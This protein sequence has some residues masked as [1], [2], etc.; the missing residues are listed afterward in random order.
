MR[1]CR[2]NAPRASP[3]ARM[4]R[5]TA[6]R[7]P[8][9]EA[10][11]NRAGR[12]HSTRPPAVEAGKP[13]LAHVDGPRVTERAVETQLPSLATSPGSARAF[14]RSALETWKL[15]GFGEV[16]ELLTNELV[17]NVVR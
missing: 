7:S 13:P 14:L 16:T 1:A 2:S 6:G 8:G 15:D 17:G 9:M 4:P 5:S 12:Q 11:P 10:A 3:T